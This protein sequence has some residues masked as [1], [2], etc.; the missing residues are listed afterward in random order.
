M[1]INL[2][3][4]I[5]NSSEFI[6]YISSRYAIVHSCVCIFILCVLSWLE[7]KNVIVWLREMVDKLLAWIIGIDTERWG[8]LWE[9]HRRFS[10][11]R[12]NWLEQILVHALILIRHSDSELR[13]Y[14][15]RIVITWLRNVNLRLVSQLSWNITRWSLLYYIVLSW[16]IY[17]TK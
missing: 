13:S 8:S 2:T 16:S 6:V 1:L 4:S 3:K 7:V 10:I 12:L 9:C 11:I 14:L 15:Y 17:G 5:F